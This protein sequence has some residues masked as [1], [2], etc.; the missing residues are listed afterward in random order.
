MREYL[1]DHLLVYVRTLAQIEARH[2]K[3]E[4][5]NRLHQGGEAPLGGIAETMLLER[6]QQVA[7]QG[8]RYMQRVS[9]LWES[10][11]MLDGDDVHAS[12]LGCAACRRTAE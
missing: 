9:G 8:M 2:V 3:A 7:R 1:A 11:Q 5:L 10:L 4:V 12:L 6:A